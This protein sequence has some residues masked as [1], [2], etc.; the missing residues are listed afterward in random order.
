MVAVTLID[1]DCDLGM[2]KI[3]LRGVSGNTKYSVIV[4]GSGDKY[5]LN[6]IFGSCIHAIGHTEFPVKPHHFYE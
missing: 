1:N 3:M 4:V 6:I 5:K 2:F